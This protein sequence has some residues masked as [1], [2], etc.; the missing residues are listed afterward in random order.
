MI[1]VQAL[2]KSYGPKLALFDVSFSVAK[3]SV[4]AFLGPNGSGK[5]TTLKILLW[6]WKELVQGE[7]LILEQTY[8]KLESPIL[9]W[10][11]IGR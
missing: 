7:A 11:S 2:T 3:G 5:S 6:S 9:R 10:C 8:Q 4:T 1:R